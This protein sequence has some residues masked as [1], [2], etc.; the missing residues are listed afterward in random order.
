MA[1]IFMQVY[2]FFFKKK[3]SLQF[4]ELTRLVE[5]SYMT[6]SRSKLPPWAYMVCT[7]K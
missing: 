6:K 4:I 2:L 3:K 5:F 1:N 7:L